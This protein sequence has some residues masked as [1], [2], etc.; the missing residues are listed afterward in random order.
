MERGT[1]CK[2]ET[3][4]AETHTQ[5]LKRKYNELQDRQYE[6]EQIL[7]ILRVRPEKDA[8]EILKRMRQG[9]D[10]AT[11]LRH[12]TVGNIM[13]QLSLVPEA[14]YRYEFPYM[15]EMPSFLTRREN[16]YLD[17]EMYGY[18][19]RT[20]AVPSQS[21][22]LPP[23]ATRGSLSPSPEPDSDLE[24]QL[25][26]YWKP[27]HAVEM[28]DPYLDEVRPSRWTNV[29]SDDG[30]MRKLLQ[31]F[32]LYESSW[33]A[34]IHKDYFLRDMAKGWHQFCS[35]LLVNAL[36]AYACVSFMIPCVLVT[37]YSLSGDKVF[38]SG[39]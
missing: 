34:P 14:R 1:K 31:A 12:V 23:T 18:A 3:N 37:Q 26:P 30:L 21:Q 19:L 6:Q 25:A 11:I 29:S 4:A 13:L 32:F 8:I 16:P 36:L 39:S 22:A 38:L 9:M 5:A 10:T 28:I 20:P 35:P 17:S 24:K 15:D 33:L 7:D 2:F 27:Y